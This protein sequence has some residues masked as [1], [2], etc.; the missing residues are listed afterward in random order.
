MPSSRARSSHCT[1]TVDVDDAPLALVVGV[2][3]AGDELAEQRV[4]VVDRR[5]RLVQHVGQPV[6]VLERAA[7]HERLD[8][9]GMGGPG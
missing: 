5:R 1:L 2:V 8:E 6:G 4:L 3:V 9:L 7:E